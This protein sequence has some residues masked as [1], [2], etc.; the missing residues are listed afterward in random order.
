MAGGKSACEWFPSGPT[1]HSPLL[2]LAKARKLVT[3][4]AVMAPASAGAV[5]GKT[6]PPMSL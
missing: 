2:P 1:E 4:V 6:N 3:L 5:L